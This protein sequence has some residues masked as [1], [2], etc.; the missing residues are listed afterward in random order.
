[1]FS[2]TTTGI[3]LKLAA[4][5]MFTPIFLVGKFTDGLYS[6]LALMAMRYLGGFA[7]MIAV[8]IFSQIPRHELTSD[9]VKTHAFRACV[10]IG[11]GT[12]IMY[13]ST[14][15]PAANATAI[16]LTQGIL[17]I[18]FAGIILKETITSRHWTAGTIAVFGAGIVVSQSID[19]SQTGFNSWQGILAATAGALFLT[20]ESLIIKFL[21]SRENPL[22]MLL[23]VNG[24]GAII[25]L[26]LVIV[27]YDVQQLTNPAL[28]LFLGLG[29][30]AIISQYLNVLAN[31]RVNASTLAPI[32]YTW[33]IFAAAIGYFAFDEIPTLLTFIGSGLIVAGGIIISRIR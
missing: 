16:S 2:K 31:I 21:T 10:G 17:I 23:Y 25:A 7:T 11:G 28:Y 6:A 24:F 26:A 18:A 3:L 20:A 1:M 30:V 32:I 5:A 27:L 9:N 4:V 29:P 33:I 14:I 19:L 15:M 12:F 8:V 13:A 22:R